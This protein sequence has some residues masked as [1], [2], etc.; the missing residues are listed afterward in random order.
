MI[1]LYEQFKTISLVLLK[2]NSIASPLACKDFNPK[3]S[4]VNP[5]I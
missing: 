3:A 4:E 1:K 2:Y 5:C